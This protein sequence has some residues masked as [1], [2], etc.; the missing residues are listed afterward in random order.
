MVKFERKTNRQWF[1]LRVLRNKLSEG[2]AARGL[3][4]ANCLGKWGLAE[5]AELGLPR[6]G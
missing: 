4:E 5:L 1:I 2:R 6:C 3:R